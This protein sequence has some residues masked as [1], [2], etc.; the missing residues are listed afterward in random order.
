VHSA[1]TRSTARSGDVAACC[2]ASGCCHDRAGAAGHGRQF[3]TWLR[4]RRSLKHQTS[5]LSRNH[6]IARSS[7]GAR[8]MLDCATPRPATSPADAISRNARLAGTVRTVHGCIVPAH[9]RSPSALHHEGRRG[10][11]DLR[12]QGGCT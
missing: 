8:V 7:A 10:S 4:L 12:S 3:G 2:R 5:S 11:P 9:C 1:S 6:S